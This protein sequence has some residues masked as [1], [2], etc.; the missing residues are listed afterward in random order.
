MDHVEYVVQQLNALG[1]EA[2]FAFACRVGQLVIDGFYAGDINR[3]RDRSP[4]KDLSFRKL[5][6]HHDLPMS[7]CAL[8]RSVCIYELCERLGVRSWKHLSTSHIRLVLPLPPTEQERVLRLAEKSAWSVRR[9]DEEVAA[10]NAPGRRP[11]AGRGGRKRPGR[12]F[13]AM[14]LVERCAR[15][16]NDLLRTVDHDLTDS[17]PEQICRAIQLL[18]TTA[19][20][21]KLLEEQLLKTTPDALTIYPPACEHDSSP[22]YGYGSQ[23]GRSDQPPNPQSRD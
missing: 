16:V 18:Q 21:C 22:E 13:Q 17:S 7:A 9:L 8:Y 15:A 23:S 5:S 10:V 6:K 1:K 3:W 12:V 4:N 19:R 2:T 11:K 20:G 14:R